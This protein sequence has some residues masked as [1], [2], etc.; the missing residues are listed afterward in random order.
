MRNQSKKNMRGNIPAY[1]F[2]YFYLPELLFKD[3]PQSLFF[4]IT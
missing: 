1:F 4:I 2:K 3:N